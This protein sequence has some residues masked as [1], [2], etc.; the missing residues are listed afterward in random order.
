MGV[1]DYIYT[2]KQCLGIFVGTG[3]HQH[4]CWQYVNNSPSFTPGL[5][6]QNISQQF[7]D[8]EAMAR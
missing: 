2:I 7:P 6:Q 5:W 8:T 1:A 3:T 4:P